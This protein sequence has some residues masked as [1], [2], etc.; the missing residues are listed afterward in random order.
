MKWFLKNFFFASWMIKCC[1]IIKVEFKYFFAHPDG[2]ATMF[3]LYSI[4]LSCQHC[5]EFKRFF[6]SF[7]QR[8]HIHCLWSVARWSSLL[9]YVSTLK[10]L[11][12]R[13]FS[14]KSGVL[15]NQKS[16]M[17][18]TQILY[19]CPMDDWQ[20]ISFCNNENSANWMDDDEE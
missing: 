11:Y 14:W 20:K 3:Y 1:R 19:E 5:Y 4:R 13:I 16:T 2:G 10:R 12:F 8:I 9:I 7:I 18:M 6:S 15:M 17:E